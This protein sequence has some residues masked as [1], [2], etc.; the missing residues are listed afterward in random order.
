MDNQKYINTVATIKTTNM[1]IKCPLCN[2]LIC[3]YSVINHNLFCSSKIE[4]GEIR[5]TESGD[6]KHNS[7]RRG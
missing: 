4:N 1:L 2:T 7:V 5:P 3:G 6:T